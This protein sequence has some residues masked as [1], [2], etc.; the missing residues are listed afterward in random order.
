MKGE[1]VWSGIRLAVGVVSLFVAAAASA[2]CELEYLQG[3]GTAYIDL[4]RKLNNKDTVEIV[5]LIPEVKGALIYGSRSDVGGYTDCFLNGFDDQSC[6]SLDFY[7]TSSG[8]RI[9]IK[10]IKGYLNVKLR[11]YNSAALRGIYNAESGEKIVETT[12]KVSN[13]FETRNDI[14]LFGASGKVWTNN[15]F[16][17]RIYSFKIYCGGELTMD[18][19]PFEKDGVPG[20]LDRSA[21]GAFY[22]NAATSGAFTPGP[23]I[24]RGEQLNIV[25]DPE[26]I[27]LPNPAYGV[28]ENLIDGQSVP[29]TAPAVWTNAQGT[30]AAT[31]TGYRICTNGVVVSRGSFTGTDVRRV[32]YRHIV[33]DIGT[34]LVWEWRREFLVT[35]IAGAG[36]SVTPAFQWVADGTVAAFT[37]TPS[38]GYGFFRWTGAPANSIVALNPL[39][40]SDLS[41]PATVTAQFG[42]LTRV[43]SYVE[44]TNAVATAAEGSVIQVAPMT[45]TVPDPISVSRGLVIESETGVPESVRLGGDDKRRVFVLNHKE[46]VLRKIVAEKG[47]GPTASYSCG[48]NVYIGSAGGTVDGCVLRNGSHQNYCTRGNGGGGGVA[49]ESADGCIVNCVITN[50]KVTANGTTQG[51]GVNMS[52]GTIVNSFIA[53]NTAAKGCYGAGAHLRGTAKMLNCT[54]TGNS[55]ATSGGIDAYADTVR[56]LNCIV[57]KNTADAGLDD[58]YTVNADCFENCIAR[59]AINGSCAGVATL[60]SVGAF[61]SP[62]PASPA[63]DASV[64]VPVVLPALDVAGNPRYVSERPDVGAAEYVESGV[65]VAF[66]TD[67]D[68]GMAPITVTFTATTYGAANVS[69]YQW[70]FDGDGSVDRTTDEPTTVYEYAEPGDFA[71]RLTIVYDGGKTV[72][73]EAPA[74]MVRSIPQVVFVSDTSAGKIQAAIDAAIDGQEIVLQANAKPYELKA[75]VNV[76]KAVVLRGE[77]GNPEDVRLSRTSGSFSVLRVNNSGATV[78]SLV[79]ENGTDGS[80]GVYGLGVLVDSAGGTVSNCVVRGCSTAQYW[81]GDAVRLIGASALLVH[82]VV[83]N[84]TTSAGTGVDR[85]AGV[86]VYGGA[87]MSNCLVC[88]NRET[89]TSGSVAVGGVLLSDDGSTAENCTIVNNEAR[90]CGGVAVGDGAVVR[91]C[92]LAGN[93]A[94]ASGAERN[95]ITP[96]QESRYEHCACDTVKIN[97]TCLKDAAANLFAGYANGDYTVAPG[98]A[99]ID[100]GADV[101]DPPELDLTGLAR[102]MNGKIDIGA[103]EYDTSKFSVGLKTD[104]SETLVPVTVTFEASL[105]GAGEGDACTYTWDFDGD[106]TVDRVTD[107]PTTQWTFVKGGRYSPKLS[108]NDTAIG[109]SASETFPNLLYLM[110]K[111]IYVVKNSPGAAFPYDSFATAA[112]T[113]AEAVSVALDDMEIVIS[114]GTHNITAQIL[115]EKK[116]D[117]HGFEPEPEKT[118]L[119]RTGGGATEPGCKNTKAG[120]FV[121]S[122]TF[123]GGTQNRPGWYLEGFGVISNCIIRGMK[124]YTHWASAGAVLASGKDALVTHCVITNNETTFLGDTSK[125]IVKV[126]G[127]ARIEN[128]LIACNRDTVG[129]S[130]LKGDAG[131]YGNCTVVS[132]SVTGSALLAASGKLGV[133]NCIFAANLRSGVPGQVFSCEQPITTACKNNLADTEVAGW[134]CEPD[135]AKVFV[136]PTANDWH[137]PV[138]SPA[139]DRGARRVA[140]PATDLDGKPRKQ[141]RVDLGC[142]ENPVG[143]GAMLLIR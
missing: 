46:A 126:S 51:G 96:G 44:L 39:T 13:S 20:M 142:F 105:S 73:Y 125:A 104:V 79:V 95:S 30:V 107:T 129:S 134:L 120:T 89:A 11:S 90:R 59:E 113:V 136:D 7:T 63:F 88:D 112:K 16:G 29:C 81:S 71:P 53:N 128:C 122:L 141:G 4:G 130:I 32:D 87:K 100:A 36:G 132:N 10:D 54:I 57:W 110:P 49:C 34:T 65:D 108:V 76:T 42:A 26:E 83:S 25:G 103:Y 6:M 99:L 33:C 43:T 72:S 92:V 98:S 116:L 102:V 106:G 52:A 5:Y 118:V 80:G 74:G 61:L 140:L 31:C 8:N 143:N 19:I 45:N 135:A 48:G 139:R 127:G 93:R 14:W 2:S 21:G 85:A 12:A 84:N 41:E 123:D 17:G 1:R 3:D 50:N 70:D 77:T 117:V 91:N 109:K 94:T 18:L 22:A 78:H 121:H 24:L 56:V 27:A 64:A 111:T 60:P 58:I 47:R 28:V 124:N 69:A 66:T 82:S 133:T 137:L 119:S 97:D 86:G 9:Q 67:I 38:A 62:T 68:R 23:Y 101:D 114:N 37:A 40:V 138:S 115:I 75:G 131:T 15:K 55:G 35:A